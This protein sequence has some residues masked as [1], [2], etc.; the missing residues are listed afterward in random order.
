ML[1]NLL[2]EGPASQGRDGDLPAAATAT[3][4]PLLRDQDVVVAACLTLCPRPSRADRLTHRQPTT[5]QQR[6]TTR[7][8]CGKSR[9]QERIELSY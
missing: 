4:L 7:D 5:T 9:R 6:T 2:R 1:L 8:S 3:T